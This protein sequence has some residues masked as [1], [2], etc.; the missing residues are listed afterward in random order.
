MLYKEFKLED[1][2]AVRE[3][4]ARAR[5]IKEVFALLEKGIPLADAKRRLGISRNYAVR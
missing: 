2:V 3:K 1:F 4:E 5:G